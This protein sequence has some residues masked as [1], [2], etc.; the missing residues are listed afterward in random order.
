M[1]V[2]VVK[3]LAVGP[4]VVVIV[5]VVALT[6]VA[7]PRAV[8]A[9]AALA[10]AGVLVATGHRGYEEVAASVVLGTRRLRPSER[11]ELAAVLT[12]LCLVGLGPPVVKLRVKR[13][14]A[15][16]ASRRTVVVS[17]GLIEAVALGGLPSRQAAAVVAHSVVLVRAG[18]TRADL[19]IDCA[20]APWR[21]MRAA[22]RGLRR[23]GRR[24][25]FAQAAWRLRAIAV[26]VAVGQAMLVVQF[27][28]ALAVASIGALSY[29]L[30]VWERRWWQLLVCAGDKGVAHTGLGD[31]LR[32]FLRTC[33]N[34]ST[35]RARLRALAPSGIRRGPGPGDA[36]THAASSRGGPR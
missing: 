4:G 5:V 30:P 24:L 27:G 26:A 33:P 2:W 23:W 12:Q 11:D 3:A 32:E 36:L 16:G 29:T 14:R 20:S 18:L 17:T 21:A 1:P 34:S 9:G 28:L 25:P 31:D 6:L 7:L 10:L 19:L 35:T 15:I 8:A 22:V 13:S